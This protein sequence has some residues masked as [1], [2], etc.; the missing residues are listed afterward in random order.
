MAPFEMTHSHDQTSAPLD[1]AMLRVPLVRALHIVGQ[2]VQKY[3][4]VDIEF[5]A[6]EKR[7]MCRMY[8]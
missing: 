3:G 6:L 8:G 2:S 1:N 5:Y 7:A 4:F